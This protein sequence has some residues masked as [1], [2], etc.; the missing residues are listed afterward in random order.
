MNFAIERLI[1]LAALELGFDRIALRR[2]NF[3]RSEQMP[4][5][6]AVGAVYD[7][8]RYEEALD[9][10]LKISDASGFEGRKAEA[11]ARGKYLGLGVSPYVESSIGSPNER[12]EITIKPNGDVIMFDVLEMICSTV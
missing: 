10:A 11:Q 7:S 2:K 12:V 1:D 9:I 8:G 5:R 4:Y 3:I 6:N